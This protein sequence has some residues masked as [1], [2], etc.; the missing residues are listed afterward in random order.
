MDAIP[1][2]ST[3]CSSMSSTP[4]ESQPSDGKEGK[5]FP[6]DPHAVEHEARAKRLIAQ[7]D[8]D[9]AAIH[10]LLATNILDPH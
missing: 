6:L 9:A 3:T 8:R 10:R 5:S 4:M 2:L 1:P 7:G